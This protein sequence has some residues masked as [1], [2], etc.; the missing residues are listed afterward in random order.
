MINEFRD[1]LAAFAFTFVEREG[2]LRAE[3]D[4]ESRESVQLTIRPHGEK[5]SYYLHGAAWSSSGVFS[6]AEELRYLL[7]MFPP[8]T[9][10]NAQVAHA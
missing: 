3:R 2:A 1:V 9:P 10:T 5:W 7:D 8:T 4:K 6:N